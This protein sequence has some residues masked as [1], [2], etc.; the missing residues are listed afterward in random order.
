[1]ELDAKDVIDAVTAQRNAA[2]DEVALLRAQ[3]ALMQRQAEE[4][5]EDK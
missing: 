4:E 5:K 3:I 2:L 1:M